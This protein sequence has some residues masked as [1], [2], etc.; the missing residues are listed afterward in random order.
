MRVITTIIAIAALSGCGATA[1]YTH[2]PETHEAAVMER[3]HKWPARAFCRN[4]GTAKATFTVAEDGTLTS[5]AAESGNWCHRGFAISR[6]ESAAP[7]PPHDSGELS[8]SVPFE[9]EGFDE[10]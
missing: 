2:S 3:V 1:T 9:F 10:N 6:V 5:V 8:Y 7:F 4:P